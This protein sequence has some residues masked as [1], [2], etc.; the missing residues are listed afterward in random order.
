MPPS[1]RRDTISYAPSRLPAGRV[2]ETAGI[3]EDAPTRADYFSET[4]QCEGLLHRHAL[5]QFFEP[6]QHDLNLR[7]GRT[8]RLRERRVD[9]AEESSVGHDVEV[10]GRPRAVDEKP[11]RQDGRLS[12]L[13]GL[14]VADGHGDQPSRRCVQ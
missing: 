11:S 3:I 13:E 9:H 7:R 4:P 2:T 10:R 1:P 12:Y 5:P 8:A 6:V 14:L